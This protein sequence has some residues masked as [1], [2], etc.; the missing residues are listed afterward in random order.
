M[1][2]GRKNQNLK[3][4]RYAVADLVAAASAWTLLF[5]FRK[6]F[7]ETAAFG[8]GVQL[9]FDTNYFLG[10]AFLPLMWVS[11]YYISGMYTDI[12]RRYRT[13]ELSQVTLVSIIGIL[14]VF[15]FF[16]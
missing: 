12:Y 13:Q 3:V 1:P 14:L 5:I 4:T 6:K 2:T 15:F 8:D 16:L 7:V 11:L 10:L 9:I